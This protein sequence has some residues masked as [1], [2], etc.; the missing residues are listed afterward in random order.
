MCFWLN[1][2]KHFRRHSLTRTYWLIVQWLWR[3]CFSCHNY[4]KLTKIC[5][6]QLISTFFRIEMMINLTLSSAVE[7]AT[8]ESCLKS[9]L[10]CV[11]PYIT[12]SST[13]LCKIFHALIV[14]S[15]LC[16][17]LRRNTKI[18]YFCMFIHMHNDLALLILI[19]I[20]LW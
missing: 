13:L 5:N 12:T 14:L 7:N 3:S 9:S 10:T 11:S 17:K 2:K 15:T 1:G 16:R 4:T 6:F 8:L 18:L 19:L 20:P